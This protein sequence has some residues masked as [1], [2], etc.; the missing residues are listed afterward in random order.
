MLKLL[1]VS[2]GSPRGI[3]FLVVLGAALL[4]IGLTA[5]PWITAVG[6]GLAF[7]RAG[8]LCWQAPRR[9]RGGS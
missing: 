1:G 5:G 7:V 4:A 3:V 6:G 9:G 2:Y 8:Y